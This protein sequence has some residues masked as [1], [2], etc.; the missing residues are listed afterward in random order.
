MAPKLQKLNFL[1]K[2][3]KYWSVYLHRD[4]NIFTYNILTQDA[5][6]FSRND[7]I[8]FIPKRKHGAGKKDL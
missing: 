8:N 5:E 4:I 6:M 7:I 1:R 3:L 2:Y